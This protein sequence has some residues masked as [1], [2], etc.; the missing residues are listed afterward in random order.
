MKSLKGHFLV[1]SKSLVD[2]N[3]ARTVLLMIEHSEAGAAGL[4]LNRPTGA[5]IAEVSEKVFE[6]TVD[7]EKPIHLGG[8]VPGPLLA[9]HSVEG[10]GDQQVL[11]GLFT[12]VDPE[13][14]QE[15]IS[16]RVEPSRF[17]ANYAG[18]G[19]GQLETELEQDSWVV[20]PADAALALEGEEA[21]MW[22]QVLKHLSANLLAE[23]LGLGQIP[24]DPNLN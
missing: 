3:F 7:W 16:L 6:Q 24:D 13:K 17:L 21:T 10:L 22:D 9:L 14:L 11:D 12:T 18:W 15:L 4:V 23:V 5:T 20:S 19:A 1:A 2:P 8:P